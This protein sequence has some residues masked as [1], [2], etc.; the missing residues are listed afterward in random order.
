MLL[1]AGASFVLNWG[2]LYYIVYGF[3]GG[4]CSYIIFL[5]IA[6]LIKKYD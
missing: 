1:H 3:M 5:L 4:I 6:P 2:D